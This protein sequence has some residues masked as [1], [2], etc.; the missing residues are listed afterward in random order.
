MTIWAFGAVVLSRGVMSQEEEKGKGSGE[1]SEE[2]GVGGGHAVT[3]AVH[4]Y[5]QNFAL[6]TRLHPVVCPEG[7]WRG[8]VRLGRS[9]FISL[10]RRKLSASQPNCPANMRRISISRVDQMSVT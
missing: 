1:V 9:S 6:A 2:L 5:T 8:W 10:F 4:L 3:L 7:F